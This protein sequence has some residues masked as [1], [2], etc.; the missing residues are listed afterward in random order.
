LKKELLVDLPKNSFRLED[1]IDYM[2]NVLRHHVPEAPDQTIAE[3]V[4]DILKL[5]HIGE[6]S[7]KTVL[8]RIYR[9]K[10]QRS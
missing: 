7:H 4:T 8:Q 6:V 9:R 10:Q 5:A 3:R 1:P 2:F